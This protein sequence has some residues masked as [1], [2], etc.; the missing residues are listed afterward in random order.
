MHEDFYINLLYKQLNGEITAAET[1]QL[2]AWRQSDPEHELQAQA[3]ELAWQATA[4]SVTQPATDLDAAFAELS[5]KMDSSASAIAPPAKVRRLPARWLSAAAAVLLLL[6]TAY[7]LIPGGESPAAIEWAEVQSGKR[8]RTVTLADQTQVHLQ[9]NSRLEYPTTMDEGIR[10]VKLTGEAFFEVSHHPEQPFIVNTRAEEIQVLG[11]S[12]F[13][14][15]LP[16]DKVAYIYVETGKVQV[17]LLQADLS[18]QLSA[19]QAVRSNRVHTLLEADPQPDPNIIS[20]HSG[21]LYFEQSPLSAIL[22][23]IDKE[24]DLDFRL[25]NP[26]LAD[27]QLDVSADKNNIEAFV[28][29][30]TT[31]FEAD[32]VQASDGTYQISGGHCP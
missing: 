3:V 14:Q 23:Q 31:I 1:Q 2:L 19:G 13:V 24:L 8:K 7:F 4:P 6:T 15:S 26:A 10:R 22:Q 20:W 28:E 18:T 29:T 27:C 16:N 32:V 5:S 25:D 11:T 17:S 21:K 9:A 30:L 12:F